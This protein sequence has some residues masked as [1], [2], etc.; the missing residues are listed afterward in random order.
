MDKLCALLLIALLAMVACTAPGVGPTPAVPTASPAARPTATPA[1]TPRPS[2][3]TLAG[4][5]FT[6]ELPD[7]YRINPHVDSLGEA[8]GDERSLLLGTSDATEVGPLVRVSGGVLQEPLSAESLL[9]LYRELYGSQYGYDL[10]ETVPVTTAQGL[11]GL[12][13]T[14]GMTLGPGDAGTGQVTILANDDQFVSLV[15]VAVDEA[16]REGYEG[17]VEGLIDSIGFTEIQPVLPDVAALALLDETTITPQPYFLGWRTLTLRDEIASLVDESLRSRPAALEGIVAVPEGEGQHPLALVLHGR[18]GREICRSLAGSISSPNQSVATFCLP[19]AAE[20]RFDVGHAN[21]VGALAE[22]GYVALAVNL[23]DIYDAFQVDDT[24]EGLDL[25]NIGDY[26]MPQLVQMHL[27][28][29]TSDAFPIALT[30][31]LDLS[32]P[33]LLLGHSRG[34]EFVVRLAE[35]MPASGLVLLAAAADAALPPPRDVPL[36]VVYGECDG[37]VYYWDSQR[38][39]EEAEDDPDRTAFAASLLLEKANHNFFNGLI[40]MTDDGGSKIS[41]PN[42]FSEDGVSQ[43]EQ[44]GFTV[45]YVRDFVRTLR[46]EVPLPVTRHAPMQL[47][48]LPVITNLTTAPKEILLAGEGKAE[49]LTVTRCEAGELCHPTYVNLDQFAVPGEPT[50]QRLTWEEAGASYTLSFSP[51]DATVYEALNLRTVLDPTSDLNGGAASI[52]YTLIMEDAAGNRATLSASTT[53][54][55]HVEPDERFG[56]S[57]MPI[58]AGATRIPLAGIEG[59]DLTQLTAVTLQFPQATGDL[60]LFDL[61]LLGD[62]AP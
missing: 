58:L 16:W 36:G 28:A 21:L 29:L 10:S 24:V 45:A 15:A 7:G 51:T 54:L 20:S 33:P 8:V 27:D 26:F 44:Q 48:G 30:G 38:Y 41:N 47:Y 32:Q 49:T 46:G 1:T 13:V 5:G 12:Q 19:G 56:F 22:E 18:F 35:T 52:E 2:A 62:G 4:A 25:N 61:S 17:E 57:A 55:I 3:S 6:Y 34:G 39:F 53:P 50:A 40:G 14:F 31:R 37:D 60:L 59:V 43:A 9:A 11:S 23:N 42:C